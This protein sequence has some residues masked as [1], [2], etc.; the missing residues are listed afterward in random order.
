VTHANGYSQLCF[1]HGTEILL[2]VNLDYH[3]VELHRRNESSSRTFKTGEKL[4]VS[5]FGSSAVIQ[6]R[7]VCAG[8][9]T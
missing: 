7:A 5:Q 4:P 6:V 3:S 2:T 8:I 9:T 1:E